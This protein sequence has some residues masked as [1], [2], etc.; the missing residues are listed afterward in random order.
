MSSSSSISSKL[1]RQGMHQQTC[2]PFELFVSS[3]HLI[4][5]GQFLLISCKQ[6]LQFDWSN[7]IKI[8]F[9]RHFLIVALFVSISVINNWAF[10]FAI[11]LTL[12]IVFRAGSLVT[13][14][15]LSRLLLNKRFSTHKYLSVFI[16][17]AGK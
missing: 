14:C 17:T 9:H 10:S 2:T 13:N 6:L 12:H 11:P 7:G 8:P 16:I 15:L 1:T 5:C 3:G 4:T